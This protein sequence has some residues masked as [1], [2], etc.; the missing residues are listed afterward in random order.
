MPGATPDR[1]KIARANARQYTAPGDVARDKDTYL[2]TIDGMVYGE[3][4]REGYFQGS[5]FLHPELK[6]QLTFPAGWQ[7]QNTPQAVS[8][9]VAWSRRGR[10]IPLRGVR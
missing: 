10:G 9:G 4:P 3:N 5:T 6:F 2:A 1:L 8:S 7:T